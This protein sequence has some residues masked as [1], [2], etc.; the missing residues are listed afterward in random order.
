MLGLRKNAPAKGF[1]FNLG[2]RIRK[3]ELIDAALERLFINETGF[4]LNRT[5][6]R[7]IGLY[8]HIYD[9]NV[10]QSPNFGTH[11]ICMAYEVF[12]NGNSLPKANDQHSFYEWRDISTILLSED[13]HENT[14]VC[15]RD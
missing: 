7:L 9:E 3:N 5:S 13:V 10:Y 11:Y 8:D 2:G 12:L 4:K 1:W 14:K 15:F 6:L